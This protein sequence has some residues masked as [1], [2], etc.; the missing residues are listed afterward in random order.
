[1]SCKFFLLSGSP[2]HCPSFSLKAWHMVLLGKGSTV[3]PPYNTRSSLENMEACASAQ[4]SPW[5]FFS[6][7]S[8]YR[9]LLLSWSQRTSGEN[10][11]RLAI[12]ALMSC[13]TSQ[14]VLSLLRRKWTGCITWICTGPEVR[15]CTLPCGHVVSS[16]ACGRKREK[17]RDVRRS[18]M[19]GH[20]R[21][22]LWGPCG[23]FCIR[24]VKHLKPAI[25][26]QPL[27]SWA[28]QTKPIQTPTHTTT[29]SSH[30]DFYRLQLYVNNSRGNTDAIIIIVIQRATSLDRRSKIKH[31]IASKWFWRTGVVSNVWPSVPVNRIWPV[32][33][34]EWLIQYFNSL[35]TIW[36]RSKWEKQ[37]AFLFL[38]STQLH[39]SLSGQFDWDHQDRWLEQWLTDTLCVDGRLAEA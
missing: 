8:N 6:P 35:T 3:T 19:C 1:M 21:T 34:P 20:A 36:L 4:G 30:R 38:V 27:A 29:H 15:V 33:A 11:L 7:E 22:R 5:A 9:I 18:W 28:A 26:P 32:C 31:K 39:Y 2:L 25:C 23:A 16:V 12:L 37:E 17:R 10:F 14:K 24:L 13:N